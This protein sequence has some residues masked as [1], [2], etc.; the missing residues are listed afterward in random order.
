MVL[1]VLLAP[2]DTT[3]LDICYAHLEVDA[4]QFDRKYCKHMHNA[5]C[6]F[7]AGA[8]PWLSSFTAHFRDKETEVS[9]K[10]GHLPRVPWTGERIHTRL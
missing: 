2:D 6:C 9:D 8:T 4:I 5:Q 3:V 10:S 1:F 7:K